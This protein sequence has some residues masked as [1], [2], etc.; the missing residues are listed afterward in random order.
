MV[1]KG[2]E[3][4]P[5]RAVKTEGKAETK[6]E[7]EVN[8]SPKGP[9]PPATSKERPTESQAFAAAELLGMS[10]GMVEVFKLFR[11]D[12]TTMRTQLDVL[13]VADTQK[14]EELTVVRA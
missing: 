3:G 4:K 7:A 12:L 8:A 9:P 10:E 11:Q 1:G 2:E 6:A 14:T 13:T 5:S